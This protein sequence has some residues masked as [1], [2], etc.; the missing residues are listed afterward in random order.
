M[1]NYMN[2][3]TYH[4][5]TSE[6]Y[7]KG[8]IK[9]QMTESTKSIHKRLGPAAIADDF[10]DDIEELLTQP[11]ELYEDKETKP[12]IIPDRDEIQNFDQYIGAKVLLPKGNSM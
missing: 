5:L 12:I 1:E 10:E 9:Q 4:S 2:A 7:H 6:E 3:S 8:E 11:F